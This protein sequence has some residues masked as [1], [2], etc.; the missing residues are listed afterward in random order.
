MLKYV[1]RGKS[2]KLDFYK[3]LYCTLKSQTKWE[4][5][6]FKIIKHISFLFLFMPKKIIDRKKKCK[7]QWNLNWKSKKKKNSTN[8]NIFIKQNTF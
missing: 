6:T 3:F 5:P 8:W 4:F 7:V 2:K 1:S